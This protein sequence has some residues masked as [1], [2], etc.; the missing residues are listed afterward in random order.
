M[1]IL[2]VLTL[3]SLS[4]PGFAQGAD[5]CTSPTLVAGLGPHAFNN[6]T[7]T[8]G[9]QAGQCITIHD[10]VWFRWVAPSTATY[11]ITTCGQANFDTAIAVFDG[12]GCPGAANIGRASACCT[13]L[14]LVT[15]AP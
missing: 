15:H 7:A 2:G 8:D 10:D 9:P 13:Q 3:L 6:A 4:V 1:R 5:A 11:T 12:A 14:R